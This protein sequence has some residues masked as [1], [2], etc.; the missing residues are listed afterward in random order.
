MFQKERQNLERLF[1]QFDANAVLAQLGGAQVYFKNP[2][3]LG[4]KGSLRRSH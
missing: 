3:P 4:S 2:K 1:L